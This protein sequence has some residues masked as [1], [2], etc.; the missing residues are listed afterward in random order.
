MIWLYSVQSHL[1]AFLSPHTA[2]ISRSERR[3]FVSVCR[4]MMEERFDF[5]RRHFN[6]I[7]VLPYSSQLQEHRH[8]ATLGDLTKSTVQRQLI[9]GHAHVIFTQLTKIE[10]GKEG[11]RNSARMKR[12]QV[13]G[14]KKLNQRQGEMA[15]ATRKS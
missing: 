8:R 14:K 10:E 1:H 3:H 11:R 15:D 6:R 9:E 12:R 5:A 7:L 4:I 13:K 2:V